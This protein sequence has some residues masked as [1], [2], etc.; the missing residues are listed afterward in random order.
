M[1]FAIHSERGVLI[2]DASTPDEARA[3]VRNKYPHLLIKKVKRKGAKKVKRK[4]A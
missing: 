4:G 2:V 3:I 1:K